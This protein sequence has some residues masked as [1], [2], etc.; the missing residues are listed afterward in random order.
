MSKLLRSF[1]LFPPFSKFEWSTYL[2]L[3]KIS[4]STYIWRE[5]SWQLIWWVN[6][7]FLFLFVAKFCQLFSLKNVIYVMDKFI[8]QSFRT[9]FLSSANLNPFLA[10]KKR[11]SITT[12]A[13]N[14]YVIF[15]FDAIPYFLIIRVRWRC[16]SVIAWY[17]KTTT[18]TKTR[19]SR[20]AR[21]EIVVRF[22]LPWI[23]FYALIEVRSNR[24]V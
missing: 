16:T 21:S 13:H 3:I 12:E 22:G 17:A 10:S 2:D 11:T 8:F 5:W 14:W 9:V 19:Y 23:T 7:V 6:V 1:K 24:Y 15:R 20:I 18:R 4:A